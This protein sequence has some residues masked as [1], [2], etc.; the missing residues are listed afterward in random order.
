MA[1]VTCFSCHRQFNVDDTA[2]A[3]RLT[4]LREEKAKHYTIECPHCRKVNKIA[5][6]RLTGGRRR[7]GR[8]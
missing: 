4:K 3:D 2:I 6:T 5:L 7:R 8:R 1:T